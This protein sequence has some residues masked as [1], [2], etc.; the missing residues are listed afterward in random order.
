MA[1]M[2]DTIS[3]YLDLRRKIQSKQYSPVYLLHGEEVYFIDALTELLERSILPE[4]ER[5]F[6]QTLIY[7]KEVKIHDLIAMARRY[8]M[9]SDYQVILVKDAQDIKEFDKL[10]SYL[11][12]PMPS[13][14]LVCAF[15]GNKMDMRTKIGK[16]ADRFGGA[17]YAAKLRDYQIKDWLPEYFKQQGRSIDTAAIQMIVELLGADLPLIHNELDKLFINVKDEFI[18]ATHIEANIGFNREYNVFELQSAL[19][20]KNFN[21]AIQIAHHMGQRAEKGEILR[22]VT[23]LHNYF[24]KILLTQQM[25]NGS[26]SE[27]ASA[28]GINPFFLDEYLGAARFYSPTDLERVFNQ[29]KLLDLRLKGVHRGSATD[30]ELLIEAIVGILRTPQRV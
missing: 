7:G 14:V 28:L 29:I 19:G 13:T 2:S 27:L 11:E 26:K 20:T 6:N 21:K 25:G 18:R 12:N 23:N 5:S 10:L 30:G 22:I 1:K 8:P 3:N 17:Y 9:M 4:A 24:G 15:R 16:Q